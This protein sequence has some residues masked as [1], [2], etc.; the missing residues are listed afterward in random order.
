MT[1]YIASSDFLARFAPS[2]TLKLDQR[3][4]MERLGLCNRVIRGAR[5]RRGPRQ[6]YGSPRLPRLP[7]RAKP[8]LAEPRPAMP[9]LPRHA[10]LWAALTSR[11]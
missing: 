7:S 6:P 8:R 1:S 9:F 10:L 4:R 5:Q 3:G 2:H 11:R